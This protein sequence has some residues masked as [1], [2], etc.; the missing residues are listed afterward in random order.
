MSCI[1]GSKVAL[2]TVLCNLPDV[3]SWFTVKMN[4]P[5]CTRLSNIQANKAKV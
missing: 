1:Y 3:I 4:I 5:N 2:G